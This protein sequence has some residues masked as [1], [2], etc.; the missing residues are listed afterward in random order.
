LTADEVIAALELPVAARVDRRVPKSLLVEHGAP[1][2]ADRRHINEGIEQVLWVA[3]LKPATIGVAAYRDEVRE[4]VEVA[5]L[6]L[7][8]REGAKASRISELLHRAIPYPVIAVMELGGGVQVTAAHKRWSLGEAGKV[9]LDGDPTTVAAP[10]GERAHREE[11]TAALALGRQSQSSLHA[12]YQSWCDVLLSLEAAR[13]TGR[14]EVL[15]TAER[16]AARREA[17]RECDRLEVE[18]ARIRSLAAKE[19]QMARRVELN[20]EFKR[21]ES[22]LAT[23]RAQL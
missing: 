19:R 2:A 1:T 4:Y 8:L 9:L 16:R 11:F 15:A 20:L 5:V 6:R 13:R 14:F 22:A 18:I 10:Q 3:A 17:L 21:A 7:T 12:L 23:A